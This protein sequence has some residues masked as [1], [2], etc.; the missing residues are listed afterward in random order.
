MR[1]ILHDDGGNPSHIDLHDPQSLGSYEAAALLPDGHYAGF[2]ELRSP[3]NT[4]VA[5]VRHA[6]LH[7]EKEEIASTMVKHPPFVRHVPISFYIGPTEEHR[8]DKDELRE[9]YKERYDNPKY[10]IKSAEIG[11]AR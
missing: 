4:Q 5:N 9:A 7:A 10:S 3:G 6:I 2:I 11:R 1:A 8:P